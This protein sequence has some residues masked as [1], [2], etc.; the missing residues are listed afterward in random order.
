MKGMKL[1]AVAVLIA[2]I[3]VIAASCSDEQENDGMAR[4]VISLTDAPGDFEEVNIDVVGVKVIIND[5]LLDLETE[6]GTINLLELTNGKHIILVDQPVPA[7]LLSQVR[8]VLGDNNSVKVDGMLHPLKTPSAQQSGLKF[9][10][11]R[12]FVPAFAYEYMIDFDAARSVVTTGNGKYNLKP[13]IRVFAEEASGAI[14]GTVY[15]ADSKPLIY[16]IS[17]SDDTTSTTSDTLTGAYF[18]NG[19]MQDVYKLAFLFD[20]IVYAD[21]T[22]EGIQVT[23]GIITVVDTVKFREL[24]PPPEEAAVEPTEE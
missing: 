14:Q 12:Q 6:Q 16:A 8:L 3:A 18:F 21:T 19:A 4:L 15:P 24:P 17:S 2:G 1:L 5:S 23:T 22:L 13:L 9:N 10:V 11:H 20:S 7:G